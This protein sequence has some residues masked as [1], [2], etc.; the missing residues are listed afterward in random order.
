MMGIVFMYP[1]IVTLVECTINTSCGG[2]CYML[3]TFGTLYATHL[4]LV[5]LGGRTYC[6]S[7]FHRDIVTAEEIQV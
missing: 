3:N 4:M 2:A 7:L 6:L 5:T 1:V